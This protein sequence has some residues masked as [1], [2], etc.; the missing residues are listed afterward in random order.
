VVATSPI[1]ES[2]PEAIVIVGEDGRIRVANAAAA[3]MFG[4]AREDLVG[5]SVE[6]LLPEA[7]RALHCEHRAGYFAA[8][9]CP[10]DGSRPGPALDR[11]HR[12]RH[13]TR[14]AFA[15]L[16]P[17]FTTKAQGTGLG[18]SVI[19]GIVRDHGGTIRVASAPGRGTT[20]LPGFPVLGEPAS[21]PAAG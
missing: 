8:P 9:P 5:L 15:G 18:P 3:D 21:G 12:P 6:A 4:Y 10:A 16:R 14:G 1:I 11:R 20:F 7:L 17:I 19:Y 2:A 13:P